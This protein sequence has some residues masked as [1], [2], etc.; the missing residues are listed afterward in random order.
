L[1]LKVKLPA[2]AYRQAGTGRGRSAELTILNLPKGFPQGIF[3]Y[4]VPLAPAY[5]AG[6]AGHLP[7][8]DAV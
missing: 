2:P 1:A 4:M 5:K 7:A 6:L 8:Q 3:S